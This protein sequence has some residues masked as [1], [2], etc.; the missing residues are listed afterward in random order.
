MTK[1]FIFVV[2]SVFMYEIYARPG[3]D[4]HRD[5]TFKIKRIRIYNPAEETNFMSMIK[6]ARLNEVK[7]GYEVSWLNLINKS[8]KLLTPPLAWVPCHCAY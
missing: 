7:C 6:G 5:E 8:L 4:W 2:L 3:P 1:L